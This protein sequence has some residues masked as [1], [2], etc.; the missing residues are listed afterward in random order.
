MIPEARLVRSELILRDLSLPDDVKLARKSLIRWLA[1]SLGFI[2]PNDSRQL[3]L[4]VFDT[5]LD[6]HV[7][8]EAPTTAQILENLKKR[9]GR[10]PNPKAVY[11]HLL[12]LKEREI[13]IRK[14]GRYYMWGEDWRPLSKLFREFYFSRADEMFKKIDEALRRLERSYGL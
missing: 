13:I 12:R 11:Y 1:L 6:F 5:L 3:L 10:D 8:K 7:R 4:D 14:K 9:T 2:S